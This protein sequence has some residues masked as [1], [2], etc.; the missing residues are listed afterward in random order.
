MNIS[1][2]G[3]ARHAPNR[4]NAERLIAYLLSDAA[5]KEFALANN[6]YPVVEGIAPSGPV[7]SFGAFKADPLPMAELGRRQAEAVQMMA[8][9][10]WE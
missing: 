2:A 6:E 8:S 3:L 4:A 1:G 10:G 9:A 5:Q 7:A